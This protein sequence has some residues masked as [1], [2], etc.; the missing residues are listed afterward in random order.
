MEGKGI[1]KVEVNGDI[2]PVEFSVL[3]D[4]LYKG[5]AQ[6]V[7]TVKIVDEET[8]SVVEAEN[9]R[10]NLQDISVLMDKDFDDG[11]G[12]TIKGAQVFGACKDITG[13]VLAGEFEPVVESGSVDGGTND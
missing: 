1:K 9:S 4:N 11:M 6:L 8:D 3:G 10:F 12:G 5:S 2:V 13:R 7:G